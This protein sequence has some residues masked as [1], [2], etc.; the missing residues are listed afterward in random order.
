MFKN[1]NFKNLKKHFLLFNLL[2][3]MFVLNKSLYSQTHAVSVASASNK[4]NDPAQDFINPPESAKP[5]VLWM[6]MGCNIS[7]AGITKDL[8]YF[9]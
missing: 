4:Q 1:I 3:M 5:G 2:L 7:K 6:W 9:F 8:E